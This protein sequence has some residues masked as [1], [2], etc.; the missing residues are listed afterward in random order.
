MSKVIAALEKLILS[1][2]KL[3]STVIFAMTYLEG[4][5]AQLLPESSGNLRWI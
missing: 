1:I 2:N 4:F 3:K 5:V